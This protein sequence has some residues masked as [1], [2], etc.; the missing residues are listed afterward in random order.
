MNGT[1]IR[2]SA[3][4]KAEIFRLERIEV[5]QNI[6]LKARF[7]SPAAIFSSVLSLFSTPD[8]EGTKSAGIFSQ[9]F[10]GLISRF[11][12]PLTLNKTFFRHSNF[13]VKTLVGVLSQKAS[14]YISEDSVGS[15]WHKLTG[16]F[17]GTAGKG[18]GIFS[19]I[20]SIFGSKKSPKPVNYPANV[21][22]QQNVL[23]T[24]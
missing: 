17:E 24:E 7:N 20:K 16:L 1:P 15:I 21:P 14:H 19:S 18:G 10:V 22:V 11:I 3:D 12:L 2:N 23:R 8:K 5:E 13:L 6:A 9:D 4:L